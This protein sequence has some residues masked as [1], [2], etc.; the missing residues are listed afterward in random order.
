MIDPRRVSTIKL[1][2]QKVADEKKNLK[3]V[4]TIPFDT[5]IFITVEYEIER[6][7]PFSETYVVSVK[8]M[9]E[10]I[11]SVSCLAIE[12]KSLIKNVPISNSTT[13]SMSISTAKIL[14]WK[15]WTP[16]DAPLTLNYH[17][18]SDEYKA[19]AFKT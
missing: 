11:L 9:I 15:L 3:I 2:K 19:I 5:P 7:K 4:E 17:Y 12:N 1:H 8:D 18:I 14:N 6:F 16:E 13:I 10:N